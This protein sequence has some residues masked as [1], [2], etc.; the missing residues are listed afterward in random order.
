MD[1]AKRKR[2]E[3]QGWKAGSADEFLGLSAEETAYIELKIDL[4]RFLA[5]ERRQRKL[6]QA[7][8][9]G[10][11]GTNQAGFARMEKGDPSVSID[12]IVKSLFALGCSR[13]SLARALHEG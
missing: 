1:D 5:K 11:A 12:R 7:E 4:G 3:K 8:A 10:R 2:L 9:G 13:D 6:T